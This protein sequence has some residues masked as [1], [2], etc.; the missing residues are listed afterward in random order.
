MTNPILLKLQ[1]HFCESGWGAINF[2]GD[3]VKDTN[4]DITLVNVNARADTIIAAAGK[5][6]DCH[7]ADVLLYLY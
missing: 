3:F 4:N 1:G 5:M 2:A 6:V 7:G